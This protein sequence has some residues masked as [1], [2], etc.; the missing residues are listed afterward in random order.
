MQFP[1][2]NVR[3]HAKLHFLRRERGK[4][5]LCKIKKMGGDAV[6]ANEVFFHDH[7]YLTAIPTD[8]LISAE[9]QGFETGLVFPS[10]LPLVP[11]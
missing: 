10:S 8:K 4:F 7:L 3:N 11:Y 9:S 2:K 6:D 1:G 5:T